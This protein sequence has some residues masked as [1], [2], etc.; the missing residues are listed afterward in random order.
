MSQ[1]EGHQLTDLR[2]L[3]GDKHNQVDS[4]GP[5]IA[6]FRVFSV[7]LPRTLAQR[8]KQMLPGVTYPTI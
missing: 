1:R 4:N 5:E 6:G 8:I 2:R 3:G 7:D